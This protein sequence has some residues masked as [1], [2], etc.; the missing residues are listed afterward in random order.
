MMLSATPSC[1]ISIACAWRPRGRPVEV[2]TKDFK[3]KA[4]GEVNPYGVYDIASDEGWV[5]VG[6]DADSA[7][8]A[9]ASIRSWWSTSARRVTPTRRR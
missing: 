5:S 9:V 4:L 2:R 7:E 1:A 8:F 6:I 3:D